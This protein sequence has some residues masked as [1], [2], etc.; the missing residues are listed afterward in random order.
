MPWPTPRRPPYEGAEP[1]IPPKSS[2]PDRFSEQRRPRHGRHLGTLARCHLFVR[3]YAFAFF[4]QRALRLNNLTV[5]L[6]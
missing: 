3:E 5:V 1:R 6:P 4:R 2:A